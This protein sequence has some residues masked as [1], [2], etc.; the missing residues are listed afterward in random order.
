MKCRIVSITL[1][2][3]DISRRSSRRE[4]LL[5]YARTVAARSCSPSLGLSYARRRGRRSYRLEWS[6]ARSCRRSASRRSRSFA[7][8]HFYQRSLA[9]R[10]LEPL[11]FKGDYIIVR[12]EVNQLRGHIGC[13]KFYREVTGDSAGAAVVER[14]HPAVE[15][16]DF[17]TLERLE[18][19]TAADLR[20]WMRKPNDFDGRGSSQ[21]Y[22]VAVASNV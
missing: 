7:L 17:N 13:A 22:P 10:R 6:L 14:C 12:V 2:T 18:R 20:R 8:S 15:F 9:T 16:A 3:A 5:G 19:Q 21:H 4:F 11:D 1:S